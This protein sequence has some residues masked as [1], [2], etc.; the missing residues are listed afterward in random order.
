MAED[1]QAGR[2]V[3][4]RIEDHAV[5]LAVLRETSELVNVVLELL[6]SRLRKTHTELVAALLNGLFGRLVDEDVREV[7]H[8]PGDVGCV[9]LLA[10][11]FAIRERK[12]IVKA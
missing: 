6:P 12:T 8:R 3:V 10:G 9:V 1:D 4:T 7:A 2:R 5:P 11:D